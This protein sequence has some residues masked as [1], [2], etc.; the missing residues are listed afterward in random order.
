MWPA[1][2]PTMAPLMHPFASR[3]ALGD[4]SNGDTGNGEYGLHDKFPNA[5][6]TVQPPLPT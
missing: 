6:P 5:S 2:P 3:R 1:T 4:D